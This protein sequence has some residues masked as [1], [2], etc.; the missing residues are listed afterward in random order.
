MLVGETKE[1]AKLV[2]CTIGRY[3]ILSVLG[4]GGV[5][6]VYRAEDLENCRSVALKLPII[7][8]TAG[9]DYQAHFTR[10]L[11]A[12]KNLHQSNICRM[13][14]YGQSNGLP[15]IT[16]EYFDGRTL[17]DTI[18]TGALPIRRALDYA[19]QI[20][21][22]LKSIHTNGFIH[23]DIKA[24]NLMVTRQDTVKILDFG[25][26]IKPR[27][28]TEESESTVYGTPAYMSPEQA[29]GE[30]VDHRTDIWSL[31]VVTYEMLTG[32]RPFSGEYESQLTYSLLNESPR[33]M[34][35]LRSGIPREVQK[36]VARALEKNREDRYNEID[37][38]LSD[39]ERCRH[40]SE[41]VPV[42]RPPILGSNM[43]LSAL[44]G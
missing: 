36:T 40:N 20:A 37:E 30:T 18:E 3:R 11:R 42:L 13:W 44:H 21:R 19:L 32:E 4:C 8:G 29:L 26:A 23:R 31:G 15:F 16:L 39:L 5:S 1:G 6:V 41:T 43:N 10:E 38:M 12:L 17:E 14:D 2:G 7:G 24:A 25:L 27:Q 35:Y 9:A 33:A 34:S 28:D 22:G